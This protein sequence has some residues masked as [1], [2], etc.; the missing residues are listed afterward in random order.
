[1]PALLELQHAMRVYLLGEGAGEVGEAG[2]A[3]GSEAQRIAAWCAEGAVHATA[4]L[5]IYRN[6]CSGTLIRALGLSYPAV[7]RVVGG[8]FFDA[9]AERFIGRQPPVSA[10]LDGYGADFADFLAG[11]APAAG[12]PYL[13]DLARLEWAVSRALH[14]PDAEGL[15]PAPAGGAGAS[16]D[17]A[18]MPRTACLDER[19]APAIP[20]RRHLARRARAG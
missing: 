4:R 5:A 17:G 1:M 3:G 2:E 8:D 10:Y 11:F 20:G 9:T 14:A 18:A 16:G 19:P 6:T 13:A 12:V 7:R 15:D